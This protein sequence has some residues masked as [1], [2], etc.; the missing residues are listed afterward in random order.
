MLETKFKN[1]NYLQFINL[2]E[3]F[4]LKLNELP[5]LLEDNI[6]YLIFNNINNK[7]YIGQAKNFISRFRIEKSVL[8]HQA[9]YQEYLDTPNNRIIYRAFNKYGLNNFTVYLIE[10]L[11]N[12]DLL[13]EREKYWIQ[14]LHTCIYDDLCWGYNMTWG[15]D[16]CDHLN[17][18]EARKKAIDTMNKRGNRYK[19]IDRCHDED[20]M[21]RSIKT[22]ADK[23]NGDCM[24]Y[25]HTP[26]MQ[27]IS[28]KIRDNL[29]GFN[30]AGM[31]L[32][33]EA[34]AKSLKTRSEKYGNNGMGA[35]H[36]PE[37]K[38]KAKLNSSISLLISYIKMRFDLL[39][40]N[41]LEI[42]PYNYFWIYKYED[43][44]IRTTLNHIENVCNHLYDNPSIIM[45]EN[46]NESWTPI[47]KWFD[48]E[49]NWNLI[50]TGKFN[51]DT[52]YN[53]NL[54]LTNK[55]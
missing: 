17:T 12:S 28:R 46:W 47:F 25:C 52:P 37:A 42:T 35:C 33:D 20:V 36:T 16:N 29:Y 48:N 50:E 10:E 38:Y 54:Y 3:L 19:G 22:R 39:K 24:G 27:E 8:S 15:G 18:P 23:Y 41:N 14:K 21:S 31:M 11:D 2:N 43:H 5:N 30:G 40:E 13:N 49:S 7:C 32:T 9:E 53:S 44:H 6:I 26:E 55:D 1:I 34:K 51:K 45:N 4:S